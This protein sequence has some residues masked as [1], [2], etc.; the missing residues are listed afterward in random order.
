MPWHVD[1]D[2]WVC[3]SFMCFAHVLLASRKT[4]DKLRTVSFT[5]YFVVLLVSSDFCNV[6]NC[7]CIIMF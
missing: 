2:A 4:C 7:V 5:I 1:V 6:C 3:L